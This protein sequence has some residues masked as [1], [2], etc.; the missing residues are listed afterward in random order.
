[1]SR[2]SVPVTPA[3]AAADPTAPTRP[4]DRVAFQNGAQLVI[5]AEDT[6]QTLAERLAGMLR[7]MLSDEEG[8]LVGLVRSGIERIAPGVRLTVARVERVI[9]SALGRAKARS[10]LANF[11][12]FDPPPGMATA[13]SAALTA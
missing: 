7:G 6:P 2:R 13:A 11:A 9:V 4:S 8:A 5:G 12:S 3:S 10:L 1:M